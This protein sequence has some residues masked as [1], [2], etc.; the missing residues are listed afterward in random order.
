MHSA[1]YLPIIYDKMRKYE[2]ATLGNYGRTP[3]FYEEYCIVSNQ[4]NF[5]TS[6]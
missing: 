5:F 6:P 4:T 3:Y 1:A 2:Q